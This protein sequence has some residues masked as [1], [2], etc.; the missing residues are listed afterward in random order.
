MTLTLW[1][2]LTSSLVAQEAGGQADFDRAIL[3][4]RAEKKPLFVDFS[5]PW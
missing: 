1:L 5:H 2:A 3:Q 4:A